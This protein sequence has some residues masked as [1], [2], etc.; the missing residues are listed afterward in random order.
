MFSP[1]CHLLYDTSISNSHPKVK[2]QFGATKKA[3][4]FD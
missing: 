4:P 2:H 3:Q 1:S